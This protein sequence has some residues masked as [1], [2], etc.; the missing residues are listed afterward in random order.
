MIMWRI[1][2]SSFYYKAKV[3]D[4]S[5]LVERIKDV[6][7]HNPCYGHRRIAIALKM[8]KKKIKRVMKECNLKCKIHTKKRKYYPVLKDSEFAPNLI[9]FTTASVEDE[10]WVTDNTYFNLGGKQVYL[11]TVLDTFTRQIKS[12]EV[13]SK[14]DSQLAIDTLLKASSLPKIL[15]SDQGVEYTSSRYINCLKSH[16][17]QLSMSKKGSPWENGY[18]ESF[19]SRLKEEI[20]DRVI[21]SLSVHEVKGVITEWIKYYNTERIHS[22]LKMSPLEFSRKVSSLSKNWGT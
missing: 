11:S 8:N 12:W 3:K 14:R 20:E 21:N 1:P 5:S 13:G 15:H 22:A 17:I 16:N 19:Y 2:K 9:K 18:Q 6:M 4:D 7:K 10:V